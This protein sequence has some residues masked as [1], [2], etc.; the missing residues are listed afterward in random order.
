M[1]EDEV[2]LGPTDHSSSN[3]SAMH[4]RIAA[5]PRRRRDVKRRLAGKTTVERFL[6][7]AGNTE[8]EKSKT[9]ELVAVMD[10]CMGAIAEDSEEIDQNI[11]T[12]K[13]MRTAKSI[14][15]SKKMEIDKR[16]ERGVDDKWP[17]IEALS[18]GEQSRWVYGPLKK[19]RRDM[20]FE[21]A[22]CK[23]PTMLAAQ[24]THNLSLL[25]KGEQE[26]IPYNIFAVMAV[27]TH[28][29]EG[30]LYALEAPEEDRKL[31]PI[32]AYELS[33]VATKA[34]VLSKRYPMDL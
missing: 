11:A 3:G 1:Y 34:Q 20:T 21:Y 10:D 23:G 31:H 9:N 26:G 17:N 14:R 32:E 19:K 2:V 30:K 4:T 16:M 22:T 6:E 25:V 5:Q 28:A 18:M 13:P 33:T 12:A 24:S 15:K 29:N 7:H 27:Y 8:S